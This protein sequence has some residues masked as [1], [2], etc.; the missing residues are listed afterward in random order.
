MLYSRMS[1]LNGRSSTTSSQPRPG[2]LLSDSISCNNAHL[3]GTSVIR[4]IRTAKH[5]LSEPH[6]IH[7]ILQDAYDV[8]DDDDIHSQDANFYDASSASTSNQQGHPKH[9]TLP[10]V[11]INM[12]PSERLIEA[13][14]QLKEVIVDNTSAQS[15]HKRHRGPGGVRGERQSTIGGLPLSAASKDDRLKVRKEKVRE[16][17]IMKTYNIIISFLFNCLH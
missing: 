13:I 3:H 14:E 8:T 9:Q 2:N 6:S 10:E 16:I 7:A 15:K 1:S 5:F 12:D 11:C 17:I 4:P